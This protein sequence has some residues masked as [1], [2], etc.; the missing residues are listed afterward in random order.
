[1][2]LLFA[3]SGVRVARADSPPQPVQLVY[4]A[5]EDCP[6]EDDFRRL[7]AARLSG[8]T[9]A[10]EP[11]E[12]SDPRE[13]RLVLRV[14]LRPESTV[15]LISFEEPASKLERTVNGGNCEELATAA[16]VIAAVTLGAQ[17]ETPGGAPAAEPGAGAENS[18]NSATDPTKNT[19]APAQSPPSAPRA[20]SAIRPRRAAREAGDR[21]WETGAGLF[22]GTSPLRSAE[23]GFDV[24]LRATTA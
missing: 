17:G 11:S 23:V 19:V 3:L 18:A 10:S 24:F 20:S 6:T 7:V 2:L 4:Q 12:P 8:R 9:L 14:E 22:V 15:A 13:P 16:A 5:P 1:M 21:A